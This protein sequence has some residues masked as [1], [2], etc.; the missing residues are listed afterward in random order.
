ME[1]QTEAQRLERISEAIIG[2][3]I[4]VHRHLG[5]G[6]LESTYAERVCDEFTRRG[7]A[8]RR[9]VFVPLSYKGRRLNTGYKLDLIVE[10]SVVAELKAV[11]RFDTNVHLAQLLT[12]LKVTDLKW[13]LLINFCV[14]LLKD[15]IR[16]VTRVPRFVADE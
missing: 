7:I 1:E 2:A 16:R 11:A 9:E 8:Y 14:P 12:Y 15:G 13:G 4:E 10:D 5:P 3:C 6:L